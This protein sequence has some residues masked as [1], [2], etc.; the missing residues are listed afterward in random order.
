MRPGCRSPSAPSSPACCSPTASSAT[1]SRRTWSR[2]RGCCSGLFF[3]SVGMSREPGPRAPGA[4]ERCSPSPAGSSPSRSLALRADRTARGTEAASPAWRLAFALPAG[5]EFA[6]VLFMLAAR[7]RLLDARTADLLVLAVTLSMM[8]GTAAADRATRPSPGA[9]CRRRSAPMTPSTSARQPGDHRRLRPLRADRRP[10]AARQ[11]HCRSPRSTAARRTSTSCAASATR[12]ITGMPRGWTC[13]ARRAR[14]ARSFLV[15]AIDDVEASTRTA[16]LVREQFPHL[17]IF[18][19]ARSRQHVFALMDAGVER[20][21]AR[22]LRLEPG[23]GHERAR[24][25][26]ARPRRR[27]ARRCAASARTTRRRSP[28]ST[29]SRRTT[30]SSSPLHARPRSSWRSCSRPTARSKAGMQHGRGAQRAG[31]LVRR[32]WPLSPQELNRRMRF[33]FGGELSEVRQPTR[34]GH[35]RRVSPGCWSAP[36][37]ASWPPGRTA[38]GG[39]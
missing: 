17:R 30:S 35:P 26:R 19:R 8:L 12:S 1:S 15:L 4:A 25:A 29:R 11:G 21:R 14:R 38:R 22:D 16:M 23:A 24:G 10:R 36:P 20:H 37:P 28:G 31:F 9:G 5:G 7:Q 34:R 33:W 2:S 39:A 27:R 3:I 6:F 32:S 13:C 18:A